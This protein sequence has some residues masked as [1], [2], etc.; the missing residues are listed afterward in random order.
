MEQ[1]TKAEFNAR[2]NMKVAADIVLFTVRDESIDN[3]RKTP[4][5]KLQVL[6]IKRKSSAEQGKWALPGGAVENNEDVHTAAYRELKEETNI[7]NVYIEQLYTW[8]K[9]DRDPRAEE[10]PQNRSVSVSYMALVDSEKLNI[11]AGDDAEDAQWFTIEAK[12]ISKTEKPK[13][14]GFAME[15]LYELHLSNTAH[16]F[17]SKVIVKRMI[18]G[19]I[20]KTELEFQESP[21]AFDHAQILYYALER[22]RNKTEYTNIAFNLMPE[23]FTLGEIQKVYEVILGKKLNDS[24]FRTR[25]IKNMVIETNQKRKE[26][27]YRHGKLYRYNPEWSRDNIW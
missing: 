23:L 1:M 26:G 16:A 24:N 13:I 27:Q 9:H 17:N 15:Y 12:L 6:L 5:L 10:D 22:L 11:Q 3:P 4:E 19:S 7:D 25:T 20:V 18:D 2:H 8:G 14:N 21:I